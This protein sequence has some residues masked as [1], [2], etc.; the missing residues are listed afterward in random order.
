[1][2]RGSAPN[3]CDP[4]RCL[5]PEPGNADADAHTRAHNTLSAETSYVQVSYPFHPLH[6]K[7]LRVICRPKTGDGAVTVMERSGGRLKIPVWML[8]SDCAG[9]EIENEPHLGKD[10]LLS[11][12]SL[13]ATAH[14]S[15]DTDHDNLLQMVVDR[16]NG[17][18][19]DATATSGSDDRKTRRA[20]AHGQKG[21]TRTHRSDGQHSG[22]GI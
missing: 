18:Q 15:A 12:E 4:A 6:G 17:G 1:M 20:S 9:I 11:L 22:G 3:V 19:R 8:S 7:T 2:W 10:A 5:P 13:L 16:S 14:T 21:A